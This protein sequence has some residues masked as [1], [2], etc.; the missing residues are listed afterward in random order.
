MVCDL[1]VNSSG[2]LIWFSEKV[3]KKKRKNKL[4]FNRFYNIELFIEKNGY[5]NG[6]IILVNRKNNFQQNLC[7]KKLISRLNIN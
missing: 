6:I 7:L 5:N 2:H 1:Y 4:N 3:N